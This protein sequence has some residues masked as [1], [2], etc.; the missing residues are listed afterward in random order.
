VLRWVG[1]KSRFVRTLQPVAFGR[2]GLEPAGKFWVRFAPARW[3]CGAVWVFVARRVWYAP[4]RRGRDRAAR[5]SGVASICG[6]E[7]A[8]RGREVGVEQVGRMRI[9]GLPFCA[10]S[11]CSK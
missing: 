6:E 8:Q 5:G 1:A 3:K 11:H 10:R 7:C 4:A 2:I 9:L